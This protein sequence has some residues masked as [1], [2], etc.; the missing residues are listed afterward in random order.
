MTNETAVE[1]LRRNRAET[2]SAK[3]NAVLA[4]IDRLPVVPA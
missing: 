4:V 2:S 3:Q 1:A